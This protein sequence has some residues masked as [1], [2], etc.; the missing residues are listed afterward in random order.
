MNGDDLCQAT[1]EKAILSLTRPTTELQLL[2]RRDPQPEEL[3]VSL[4][5]TQFV[6]SSARGTGSITQLHTVCNE[7]L[8]SARGTGGITQL[9]TVCI[10]ISLRDWRYH[11]VTHVLY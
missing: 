2:V 8:S 6:L 9:Y 4:S 5:Y 1:H 7:A 11:S 10:V 3:E